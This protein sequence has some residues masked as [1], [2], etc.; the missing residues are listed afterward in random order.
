MP[1]NFFLP[2]VKIN[3]DLTKHPLHRYSSF[4]KL[5]ELR[6]SACRLPYKKQLFGWEKNFWRTIQYD[7][8]FTKFS[9][10][11][12]SHPPPDSIVGFSY[13]LNYSL[14]SVVRTNNSNAVP[15]SLTTLFPQIPLICYQK[16]AIVVA[17]CVTTVVWQVKYRSTSVGFRVQVT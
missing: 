7:G 15:P 2:S 14:K 13:S 5:S 6:F 10:L 11:S 16:S 8:I 9:F 4:S 12:A 17:Q 3:I 1:I